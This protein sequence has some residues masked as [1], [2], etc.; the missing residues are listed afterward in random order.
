MTIVEIL[1][2]LLLLRLFLLTP[3]TFHAD[4]FG[5]FGGF[6]KVKHYNVFVCSRNIHR[7][8]AKFG[9]KGD[10]IVYGAR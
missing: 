5:L 10:S 6:Q 2:L 4:L 9:G 3:T 7:K 8:F 1:Q